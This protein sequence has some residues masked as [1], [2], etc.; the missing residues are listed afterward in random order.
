MLLGSVIKN[1]F[2]NYIIILIILSICKP[3]KVCICVNYAPEFLYTTCIAIQCYVYLFVFICCGL[4]KKYTA[5]KSYNKQ[6]IISIIHNLKKTL[7]HWRW[8][9]LILYAETAYFSLCHL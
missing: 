3:Y 8:K 9:A 6:I 5:Y 2:I 7:T 1:C 4:N